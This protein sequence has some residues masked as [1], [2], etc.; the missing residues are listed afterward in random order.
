MYF[1]NDMS[2]LMQRYIG[3]QVTVQTHGY[4]RVIGTL[5]SVH[6]SCILLLNAI[7]MHEI[8]DS[9]WYGEL[10]R[11]NQ[12]EQSGIGDP[13]TLIATHCITS[14][15]CDEDTELLPA[16][17][18]AEQDTVIRNG[19]PKESLSE[20]PDDLST[21]AETIEIRIGPGLIG[22]ANEEVDT[23]FQSIRSSRKTI[24]KQLGFTLPKIRIRD[25]FDL[26]ADKYQILL[27]GVEYATSEVRP[28]KMLAIGSEAGQD[29]LEGEQVNEPAFGLRATWIDPAD[30]QAAE[31]AGCTVVPPWCV[32]TTHI[33]EI[34]RRN[35]A[36]LLTYD[37]TKQ[38]LERLREKASSLVID[39]YSSGD[40]AL[41]LHNT[42]RRLLEAGVSIAHVEPIAV[43]VANH[44]AA[45][46]SED[47]LLLAV[48]RDILPAIRRSI[49]DQD[50]LVSAIVID[51]AL[52]ESIADHSQPEGYK[53]RSAIWKKLTKHC[54][55]IERRRGRLTIA[56]DDQ[57]FPFFQK[58]LVAQGFDWSVVSPSELASF[59]AVEF[60]QLLDDDGDSSAATNEPD[61]CTDASAPRRIVKPR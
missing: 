7:R 31:L 58:Q 21:V 22:L 29:E 61:L 49:E 18:A 12:Q 42:F 33:V 8:D 52:Q 55:D 3:L 60:L 28:G 59:P 16:I 2:K 54:E 26:D 56:I 24:C 6:E 23:Q 38:I 30:K 40:A 9:R 35:A 20:V 46:M 36:Q 34:A 57:H 51:E 47:D 10:E 14:I 13:E 44:S 32:V 41:R 45:G 53:R 50:G 25:T 17:E 19:E 11:A 5:V 1:D 43:S 39:H 4:A 15:S 37:E 27:G 48:R